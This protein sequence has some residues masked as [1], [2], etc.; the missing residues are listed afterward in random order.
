MYFLLRNACF[1][2]TVR[3][4]SFCA[5]KKLQLSTRQTKKAHIFFIDDCGSLNTKLKVN[6]PSPNFN[7]SNSKTSIFAVAKKQHTLLPMKKLFLFFSLF[8]IRFS[9]FAQKDS[10]FMNKAEAQNLI[11]NNYRE[12]KW[13]LYT[14]KQNKLTDDTSQAIS[15][16]LINFNPSHKPAGTVYSFYKNDKLSVRLPYVNGMKN[17]TEQVYSET[18]KLAEEKPWTDG[19]L[20]GVVKRYWENGYTKEET[21]YTNGKEN[22]TAKT[23]YK[24]G[25]LET[26]DMYTDGQKNGFSRAWYENGHM[27]IEEPYTNGIKVGVVKYYYEDGKLQSETPYVDGKMNGLDRSY[28][29]DGKLK[30]E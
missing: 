11:V 28:Y 1:F 25:K 7:L 22:G 4:V 23:Y 27:Q 20:N 19:E 5:Y 13:I 14:D 15:Y 17:G 18:G 30:S 2:K 16:T 9:L 21:L 3:V 24:T 8:T 29:E 10:G 26:E 6:E 12:G